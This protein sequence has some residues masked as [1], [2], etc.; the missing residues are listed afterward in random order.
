MSFTRSGYF[1]MFFTMVAH[2][3]F[4][5]QSQINNQIYLEKNIAQIY[6]I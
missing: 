5:L 1:D 4:Y 3:K 2:E 6:F